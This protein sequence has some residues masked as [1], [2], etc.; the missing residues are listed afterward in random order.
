MKHIDVPELDWKP[1]RCNDTSMGL[2]NHDY[3][4]VMMFLSRE[5]DCIK[6]MNMDFDKQQEI[7]DQE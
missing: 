1:C 4:Q 3:I 2:S 7:V 5:D 6:K